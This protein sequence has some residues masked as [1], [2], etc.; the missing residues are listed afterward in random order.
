MTETRRTRIKDKIAASQERL[1]PGGPSSPRK[2]EPLPDRY[3]PDRFS[4]LAGEY[5]LLAVAGGLAAG[6]V[7]A[8]LLPRAFGRKFSRRALAA[9]TVAGELGLTFGKQAFD[10]ASEASREAREKLGERLEDLGETIDGSTA[11]V[12]Q[13][14]TRAAGTAASNA[15]STGLKIA[16]GAIRIARDASRRRA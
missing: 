6:V 7:I 5:P 16:R 4:Q 11:D 3:P 8:A 13:R 12:R 15:R 9:A 14:A 10:A 1:K 2:L